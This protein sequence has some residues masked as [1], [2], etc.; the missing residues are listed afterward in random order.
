MTTCRHRTLLLDVQRAISELL[1]TETGRGLIKPH[2]AGQLSEQVRA[3]GA[4]VESFAQAPEVTDDGYD[5]ALLTPEEQAEVNA[6][7]SLAGV[8]DEATDVTG[9]PCEQ[10]EGDLANLQAHLREMIRP[11]GFPLMGYQL[12][13]VSVA[14]RRVHELALESASKPGAVGEYDLSVPQLLRLHELYEKATRGRT[15]PRQPSPE[16]FD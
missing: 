9:C 15:T 7:L 1:S 4:L 16:S 14:A 2:E 11:G 3:L 5:A 10:D 12:S 13:R 6:L 8:E